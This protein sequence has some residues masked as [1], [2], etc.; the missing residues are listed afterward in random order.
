MLSWLHGWEGA[1]PGFG[2]QLVCTT[3]PTSCPTA[4]SSVQSSGTYHFTLAYITGEPGIF[5]FEP[6]HFDSIQIQR[7]YLVLTI[8]P[9]QWQAL[10][11]HL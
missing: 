11:F 1:Q 8:L 5:L 3:H 9:I 2:Y 4:G 6:V 10:R 7:I